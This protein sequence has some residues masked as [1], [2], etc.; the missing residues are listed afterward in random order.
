MPLSSRAPAYSFDQIPIDRPMP[1]IDR[2]RIIGSKMMISHVTLHKGLKVATH[3]HENEQISVV[4]SGRIRFSI[5]PADAAKFI[6]LGAGQVVHLP[7]NVPHAAEAL[8]E[9]VLLDLFSPPSATTGVDA[10]GGNRNG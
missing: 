4:L 3:H 6:E 8:E 5:G 9:C 7:G 1:L 10:Q 2:K